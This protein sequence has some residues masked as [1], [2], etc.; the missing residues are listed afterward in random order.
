METLIGWR[1]SRSGLVNKNPA[2]RGPPR[3]AGL[4]TRSPRRG[5]PGREAHLRRISVPLSSHRDREVVC[6]T[7]STTSPGIPPPPLRLG[8]P[9][10]AFCGPGASR[11]PA[12]ESAAPPSRQHPHDA[13]CYAWCSGSG[14]GAAPRPE[15]AHQ[16][17]PSARQPRSS[18]LRHQL[19]SRQ[20]ASEH[21]RPVLGHR[22]TKLALSVA[23]VL[24]TAATASAATKKHKIAVHGSAPHTQAVGPRTAPPVNPYSPAATG[25]GTPGYNQM[26]ERY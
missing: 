25:G 1:R 26:L 24:S 4:D 13:W 15:L 5:R 17:Q 19:R 7:S 16:R 20:I 3:P 10:S 9:G 12:V 21:P 23:I 14:L 6:P 18:I 8:D 2:R 22:W 11:H